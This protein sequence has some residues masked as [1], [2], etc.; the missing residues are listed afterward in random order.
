M[1]ERYAEYGM[2]GA[3]RR[4]GLAYVENQ[5][6]D[7]AANYD[8]WLSFKKRIKKSI[9]RA[10][11]AEKEKAAKKAPAFS[12]AIGITVSV[13]TTLSL[14]A[15]QSRGFAFAVGGEVI[16]ALAAGVGVYFLLKKLC[17]E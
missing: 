4:S 15:G 1:A 5:A 9:S 6:K 16:L 11:S 3:G 12:G 10:I 8:R 7:S 2:V 14:I 17:K 13:F